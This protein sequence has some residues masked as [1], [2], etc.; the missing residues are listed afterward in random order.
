VILNTSKPQE[1]VWGSFILRGKE[2][3][4]VV[5]MMN[6]DR[7]DLY[8]LY[9]ILKILYEKSMKSTVSLMDLFNSYRE[10]TGV[11]ISYERF[12]KHVEYASKTGLIEAKGER[13]QILY[14]TKKGIDFIFLMER[15]K[16][17]VGIK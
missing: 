11:K 10:L 9:V 5:V 15:I 6:D 16:E 13:P 3:I 14:L 12:K 17:L 1:L 8:V 7:L 4:T 2:V